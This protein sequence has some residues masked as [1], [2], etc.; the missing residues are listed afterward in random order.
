[1]YACI[2]ALPPVVRICCLVSGLPVKKK[3]LSRIVVRVG[4]KT[5]V[6]EL[7]ERLI[8]VLDSSLPGNVSVI[9]ALTLA[10]Y[11]DVAIVTG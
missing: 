4:S 3:K 1:M 5:V 8:D 7:A 9:V 10:L 2:L 6:V 11:V